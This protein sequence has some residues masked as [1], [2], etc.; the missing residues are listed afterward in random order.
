MGSD[1]EFSDDMMV[2]VTQNGKT[3]HLL[4][5]DGDAECGQ[6]IARTYELGKMRTSKQMSYCHHCFIDGGSSG[7]KSGTGKSIQEDLYG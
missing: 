1:R 2:G 6:V 3:Y 5:D 4:D 7:G